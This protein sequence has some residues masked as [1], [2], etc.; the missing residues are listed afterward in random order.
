[1]TGRLEAEDSLMNFELHLMEAFFPL[2][3]GVLATTDVI[4]GCREVDVAIILDRKDTDFYKSQAFAL[5]VHA[6]YNCKV[7][8][9]LCYLCTIYVFKPFQMMHFIFNISSNS[10]HF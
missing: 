10:T 5:E 2:L 6:A 4:V 9:Q 1:M 3:K 8:I 7:W